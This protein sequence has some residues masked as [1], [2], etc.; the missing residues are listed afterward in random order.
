MI[1][2]VATALIIVVIL[3]NYILG[4]K[5][6]NEPKGG[7]Y[8]SNVTNYNVIHQKDI[9]PSPQYV[10]GISSL[11]GIFIGIY[12]FAG[13]VAKANSYVIYGTVIL[14]VILYLIEITRKIVL[15]ENNLEFERLF[16]RTKKI[17]LHTIDGMYI[18]SFNKKFLDKNALTT[19]LVVTTDNSRY[20]FTLS[21]ISIRAVL[22]MMKENFNISENK[23]YIQKKKK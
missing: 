4:A 12:I 23:M 8:F 17:P 9:M 14:L 20:K 13:G 6:Y 2:Y 15:N 11:L 5:L 16:F 22:N 1:I 10:F 21:G 3:I 7:T 18:Y 19:K